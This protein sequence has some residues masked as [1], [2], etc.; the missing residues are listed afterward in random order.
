M[1]I[2]DTHMHLF[3]VNYP[4]LKYIWLEDEFIDEHHL[5]ERLEGIKNYE[6]KT[7]KEKNKYRATNQNLN[8]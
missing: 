5:R 6:F 3:G 1:E 8:H 4:D 2:V 7:F